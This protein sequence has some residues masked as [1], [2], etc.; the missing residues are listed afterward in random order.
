[1]CCL[2]TYKLSTDATGAS[3]LPNDTTKNKLLI[4]GIV[5][6]CVLLLALLLAIIMF[7]RYGLSAVMQQDIAGIIAVGPSIQRS[8]QGSQSKVSAKSLWPVDL[9]LGMPCA[10]QWSRLSYGVWHVSTNGLIL[11]LQIS[12]R[13]PGGQQYHAAVP[14]VGKG[15][16]QEFVLA[17]QRV[18]DMSYIMCSAKAW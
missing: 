16:K 14:G 11:C 1:M 2:Q 4:A 8:A 9:K 13:W 7:W 10:I 15:T 12:Q 6:A 3:C 17:D 5:L 18:L